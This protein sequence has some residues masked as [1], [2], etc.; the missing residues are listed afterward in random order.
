MGHG[1]VIVKRRESR[2]REPATNM[3]IVQGNDS[4]ILSCM[5]FV[6]VSDTS[7]I[8]KKDFESYYE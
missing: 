6:T 1:I 4:Q 3:E 2:D 8:R 5:M 7:V